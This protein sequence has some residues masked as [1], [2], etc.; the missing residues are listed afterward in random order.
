[1]I[2]NYI[3]YSS[4]ILGSSI[5]QIVVSSLLTEIG[6]SKLAIFLIISFIA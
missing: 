5:S 2:V 3:P 6:L 1:M 4:Y